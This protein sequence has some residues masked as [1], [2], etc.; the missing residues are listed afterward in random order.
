M[1]L[2]SATDE[3]RRAH[4]GAAIGLLELTDV[5]NT[6]PSD[7]LDERKRKTEADLRDRY[8]GFTRNDFRSLPVMAAYDDT[9]SASKRS[10][11]SSCRSSPSS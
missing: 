2:I 11:T 4:P 3:W 7:A 5:E 8:R 9:T 1:I 6:H 10:I